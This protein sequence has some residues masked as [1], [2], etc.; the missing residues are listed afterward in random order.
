MSSRI[1]AKQAVW[2][3]CWLACMCMQTSLQRWNS[4][5][6]CK[7]LCGDNEGPPVISL[8]LV[9]LHVSHLA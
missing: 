3:M 4:K 2:N 5:G 6:A 8:L 1:F 7:A 9:L